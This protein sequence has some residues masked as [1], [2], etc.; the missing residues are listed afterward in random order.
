M[1]ERG[2]EL[3]SSDDPRDRRDVQ[4]LAESVQALLDRSSSSGGEGSREEWKPTDSYEYV[5]TWLRKHEAESDVSHHVVVGLRNLQRTKD[6]LEELNT[7]RDPLSSVTRVFVYRKL[8]TYDSL[9]GRSSEPNIEA[10]VSTAREVLN[11]PS[12]STP[13]REVDVRFNL[14]S[15]RPSG[16]RCSYYDRLALSEDREEVA[17]DFR[18]SVVR[19]LAQERPDVLLEAGRKFVETGQTD[20]LSPRVRNALAGTFESFADRLRQSDDTTSSKHTRKD[21]EGRG[22]QL[23]I[24]DKR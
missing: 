18:V 24:K 20:R 8:L 4:E 15:G 10:R 14:L 7:D 22:K 5:R 11:P 3:P 17:D 6:A 16:R 2:K 1:R 13:E 21:D 19:L 12:S 23:S 9:Y